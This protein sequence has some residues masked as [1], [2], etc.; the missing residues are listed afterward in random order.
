MFAVAVTPPVTV[1]EVAPLSV[2]H[3]PDALAVTGWLPGGTF[4][5][6]Y[7]PSPAV[8][9]DRPAAVTV[10]PPAGPPVPVTVPM[11]VPV[12]GGGPPGGVNMTPPSERSTG[13]LCEYC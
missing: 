9:A 4:G 10:S 1:T 13:W 12:L 3:R 7:L 6:V 11:I 8:V 2:A 5:M